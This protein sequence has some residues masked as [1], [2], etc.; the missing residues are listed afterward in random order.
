MKNGKYYPQAVQHVVAASPS[1]G[2]ITIKGVIPQPDVLSGRRTVRKLLDPIVG[3]SRRVIKN[4]NGQGNQVSPA[5][6][7]GVAPY[8][9]KGNGGS[10]HVTKTLSAPT[11]RR[12]GE[13]ENNELRAIKFRSDREADR[14]VVVITKSAALKRMPFMFAD[15]LTFIVPQDAIK[16][17]RTLRLRFNSSR[18]LE[19]DDLDPEER[20][21]IRRFQSL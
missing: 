8:P 19:M 7:A 20:S 4:R 18:V 9:T 3:I 17:L 6:H 16:A 2:T 21:E 1:N 11:F 14:A 13:Y 12:L 10:M 15:G 5:R